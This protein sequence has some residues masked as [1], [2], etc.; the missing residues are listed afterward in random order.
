MKNSIILSLV[1]IALCLQA[2]WA[3]EEGTL[4]KKERIVNGKSIYLLAGPSFRFNNKS[5]YSGGLNL[6]AGFLKRLNR[7]TS[8]GASLNYSKFNFDQSLS[9]SFENADA[10]GN[11]AFLEDGGY[12]VYV[13]YMEGGNLNFLSVGLDFKLEFIP[14]SEE[15]KI[16]AYGL[17]KPFILVSKRSNVSASTELWYSNT[18]PFILPYDPDNWSGGDPYENLSSDTPGLERWAADTEFSGGLGLGAGFDYSIKSNI[19]IF[20]QSTLKFTLPITHIKTNSFPPSRNDGYYHPDYPFVKE[21]FSTINLSVGVS[22]Y[23]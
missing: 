10:I 16:S 7:I 11:N 21:G 12:E 23:F 3:Q 9:N 2:S 8:V 22:Y 17:I 5:D 15:R 19:K 14:F 1:F 13:V 6:E 4:T 20:M 18:N